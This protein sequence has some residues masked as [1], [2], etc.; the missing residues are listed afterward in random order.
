M[1]IFEICKINL[2]DLNNIKN[3][4]ILRKDDM[5]T[6]TYY[7]K[8]NKN[9]GIM[10]FMV[11]ML[12]DDEREF[13]TDFICGNDNN[14]LKIKNK[15]IISTKYDEDENLLMVLYYKE[16]KRNND[17]TKDMKNI[18]DIIMKKIIEIK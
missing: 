17:I 3:D 14:C 8:I 6:F 1:S 11:Y 10:Y 2:I 16:C 13:I 9:I 4:K 15:S 18:T 12:N 7:T 5:M